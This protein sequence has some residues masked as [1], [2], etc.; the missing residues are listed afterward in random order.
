MSYKK[1]E[2]AMKQAYRDCP[3]RTLH[4]KVMFLPERLYTASPHP[5]VREMVMDAK[6]VADLVARTPVRYVLS[7]EVSG[8]AL[9]ISEEKGET[10]GKILPYV[11]LPHQRIMIEFNEKGRAR[12]AAIAGIENLEEDNIYPN[13]TALLI[14]TDETGRRGT[15]EMCC[16]DPQIGMMLYPVR[17]RFDL[18]NPNMAGP[19]DRFHPTDLGADYPKYG[20]SAG[21]GSPTRTW[22]EYTRL[23]QGMKYQWL[24]PKQATIRRLN[25]VMQNQPV[26]LVKEFRFLVSTLGMFA[27]KNGVN[28]EETRPEK[29][30]GLPGG[31]IGR[32]LSVQAETAPTILRMTM[33]LSRDPERDRE[34]KEILRRGEAISSPGLHWVC[35]H[36]KVRKTG[37]YWWSPHLRGDKDHDLTA[38]PREVNVVNPPDLAPGF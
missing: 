15:M 9:A 11:R 12:M 10:L 17:L 36:F 24:E 1:I 28:Y 8:A 3:G 18:D 30:R 34:I 6:R 25:E 33:S 22:L 4:E 2:C 20:P 29:G 13:H 32:R 19:M 23:E 37:V 21:D 35:G 5:F 7:D 31:S 26:E 38:I 16:V 14:E 27:L